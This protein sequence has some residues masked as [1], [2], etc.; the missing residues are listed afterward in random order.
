MNRTTKNTSRCFILVS[1]P[2][3]PASVKSLERKAR[4]RS[5]QIETTPRRREW[6]VLVN[7][8]KFLNNFESKLEL[9]DFF[10]IVPTHCV[11]LNVQVTGKYLS[12]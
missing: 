12:L 1:D 11:A 2:Y 5:G 3:D 7:F 10:V 8:E 9:M 4:S 6:K